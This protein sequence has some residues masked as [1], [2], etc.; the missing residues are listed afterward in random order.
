MINIVIIEDDRRFSNVLKSTFEATENL[1]VKT[2]YV[3]GKS[4][5]AEF[6]GV[7]IDIVLLDI[8]L[9]DMSGIDILKTLIVKFPAVKYIMCTSFDDDVRIFESLK[10]GAD[11]YIVKSDVD[12]KLLQA[13]YDVHDGGSMMSANIA[14]KVMQFFFQ[15]EKGEQPKIDILTNQENIILEFLSQGLYY[16]EIAEKTNSKVTTIKKH[17]GNIYKKL[18][19]NNKTE[20]INIYLKR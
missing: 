4:T 1:V 13:I 11:G 17:T 15:Q 19:I 9:P 18:Q 5:L 12:N 20:A 8:N 6:T 10:N 16:K 7:G 2:Q 3:N 14:K